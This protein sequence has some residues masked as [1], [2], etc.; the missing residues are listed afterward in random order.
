MDTP[1]KP[2]KKQNLAK[3]G[4]L[5]IFGGIIVLRQAA[6][7][8]AFYENALHEENGASW[9]TGLGWLMILGGGALLLSG[10]ANHFIS[11]D[12]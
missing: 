8:G 6:S 7:T 2:K 10:L 9:A 5:L 4:G 12:R 3:I 1:E 11:G